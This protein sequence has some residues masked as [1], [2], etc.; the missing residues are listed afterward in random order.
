MLTTVLNK[1]AIKQIAF[2]V[3]DLEQASRDHS[4]CFGSG[5][6]VYM[7]TA[8][9]AEAKLN[10]EDIDLYLDESYGQYG[11]LQVEMIEIP[12]TGDKAIFDKPG[13]HHFAIWADDVDEA[14][15]DFEAAGFKSVLRMVSGSGQVIN[16]IDCTEKWG[17]Y[18]ELYGPQVQ[19]MGMTQML[20]QNWVGENPYISMIDLQKMMQKG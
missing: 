5:P 1:Y 7:P 10:G 18:I 16:F 8:T 9:F 4:A 6:F 3:E 12:K 11:D 13:F 15:A 19:F 2:V 20:A 14:L 17:H